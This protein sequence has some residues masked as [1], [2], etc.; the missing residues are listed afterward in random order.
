MTY[1]TQ[2]TALT[3]VL[4]LAACG[5]LAFDA[6]ADNRKFTYTYETTT[7]PKGQREH[8]HWVTWKTD[9]NN[10]HD[11]DQLD[12]RHEIE[13]G[14]TD[15]F[16]L[17]IY[18]SDWTYKDGASVS[19]NGT[20]WK[21]AAVEAIYALT[22]PTADDFGSALYGEVKL[23]DEKFVLE[24]KIL[25]QKNVGPWIFAYNGTV[26]AEWEGEDYDED[27]GEFANTLGVSYQISPKLSAGVELVHEVE[28]DDWKDWGDDVLYAGPVVSSASDNWWFAITQLFQVT[29]LAGEPDFQTRMIVGFDF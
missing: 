12:F 19:N 15:N 9:K 1:T 24:G 26:E 18:V 14:V 23:G 5:V 27:K 11:F 8:E 2:R 10:D 4:A 16:Q 13:W 7:M 22:D 3:S 17:A 6:Q 28:Y 21:N 25:L 29:D 20:D